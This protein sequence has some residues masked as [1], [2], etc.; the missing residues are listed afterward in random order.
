[1]MSNCPTGASQTGYGQNNID[2]FAATIG[3]RIT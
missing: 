1:M 2:T 3:S